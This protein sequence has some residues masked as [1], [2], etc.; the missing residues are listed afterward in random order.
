MGRHEQSC[1]VWICSFDVSSSRSFLGKSFTS[2]LCSSLWRWRW[3]RTRSLYPRL[4]QILNGALEVIDPA[5][6]FIHYGWSE[7]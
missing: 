2:A 3:T 5:R 4:H 7:H 1:T 6:H